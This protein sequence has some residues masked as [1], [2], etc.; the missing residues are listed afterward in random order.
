M[1]P[2]W[3]QPHQ[4]TNLYH[5][6]PCNYD[7]GRDT[8]KFRTHVCFISL[9]QF[10]ISY[11][12]IITSW[13]FRTKHHTCHAYTINSLLIT[14]L[15]Q[16]IIIPILPNNTIHSHLQESRHWNTH[17]LNIHNTSNNITFYIPRSFKSARPRERGTVPAVNDQCIR[18]KLF[19]ISAD[20]CMSDVGVPLW[21]TG[22]C[23]AY[24]R[25]RRVWSSRQELEASLTHSV[26]LRFKSM[27]IS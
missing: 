27:V 9:C 5:R 3:R 18:C 11:H 20:A 10:I 7:N 1:R 4:P 2:L 21:F 17:P 14:I 15:P 16:L 22:T 19:T 24:L 8:I 12:G 25:A 13:I 23:T 26:S 6:T